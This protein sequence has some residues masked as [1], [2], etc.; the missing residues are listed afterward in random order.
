M[1]VRWVDRENA[2]PQLYRID[3]TGP[4]PVGDV[5]PANRGKVE[6]LLAAR[7]GSL[8]Q[9]AGAYGLER[10]PGRDHLEVRNALG[11]GSGSCPVHARRS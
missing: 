9:A 4:V 7:D 8:W 5:I 6:F 3:A 10:I 2:K 1:W 11:A